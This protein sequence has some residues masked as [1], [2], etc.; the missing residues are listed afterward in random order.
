[1]TGLFTNFIA[2]FQPKVLTN[3]EKLFQLHNVDDLEIAGRSH[4]RVQQVMNH[5]ALLGGH[6]HDGA[7]AAD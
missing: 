5:H 7:C 4:E 1:M 6:L 3:V 2:P